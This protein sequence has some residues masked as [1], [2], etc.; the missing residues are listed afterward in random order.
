[1]WEQPAHTTIEPVLCACMCVCPLCLFLWS[2][3]SHSLPF[4]RHRLGVKSSSE[5]HPQSLKFPP[6]DFLGQTG[7]RFNQSWDKSKTDDTSA[8]SSTPPHHPL[9]SLILPHVFQLSVFGSREGDAAFWFHILC[10]SQQM[11]VQMDA[12][13]YCVSMVQWWET[14]FSLF[15]CICARV[16]VFSVYDIMHSIKCVLLVFPFSFPLPSRTL[17]YPECLSSL[18]AWRSAEF[19]STQ[20]ERRREGG[21]ERKEDKAEIMSVCVCVW[22]CTLNVCLCRRRRTE[23]EKKI[24]LTCWQSSI[25]QIQQQE[26]KNTRQDISL[27]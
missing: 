2:R 5:I 4:W 18:A 14:G 20:R 26:K 7:T 19:A 25:F 21:R 22:M 11:R 13:G 3:L 9:S 16:C 23:R 12:D 6:A 10:F 1:M 24:Y 8:S 15:A 17:D 27:P